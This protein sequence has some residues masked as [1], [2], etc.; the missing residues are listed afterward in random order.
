MLT[1]LRPDGCSSGRAAKR[2]SFDALA[3]D[4]A[5]TV[6]AELDEVQRAARKI[7]RAHV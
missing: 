2:T 5:E 7:G 1:T 3:P 4:Y 6:L